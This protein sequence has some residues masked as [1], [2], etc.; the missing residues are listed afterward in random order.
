M[1]VFTWIIGISLISSKRIYHI[2]LSEHYYWHDRYPFCMK[3]Y[4]HS[5]INIFLKISYNFIKFTLT[6]FSIFQYYTNYG[7]S[8]FIKSN[9][10]R[11]IFFYKHPYPFLLYH[12]IFLVN[13]YKIIFLFNIQIFW[14]FKRK[15]N[16]FF[17]P[18]YFLYFILFSFCIYEDFFIKYDILK[19]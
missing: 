19:K 12:Q 9:P 8:F 3:R 13:I 10:F 6:F 2:H 7:Y 16:L 15:C 18:S 4:S 1:A 14:Y 11:L 17:K 5:T